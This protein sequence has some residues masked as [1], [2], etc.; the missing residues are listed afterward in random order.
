MGGDALSRYRAIKVFISVAATSKRK[1][2]KEKREHGG[3]KRTHRLDFIPTINCAYIGDVIPLDAPYLTG[4]LNERVL[5][6]FINNRGQ[7]VE[8]KG[9]SGEG[10]DRAAYG[11]TFVISHYFRDGT[12]RNVRLGSR[13]IL[14]RVDANLQFA[15]LLD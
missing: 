6:V 5:C 1:R 15:A 9:G 12:L 7:E 11:A 3:F 4:F 14:F 2:E 8:S 10:G 13:I